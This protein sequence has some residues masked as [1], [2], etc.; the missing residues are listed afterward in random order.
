[1][2]PL[3]IQHSPDMPDGIAALRSA[4]NASENGSRHI[5]YDKVHHVLAEGNFVLCVCEGSRGGVHSSFYDLFRFYEG[6]IRGTL[7]YH[8]S[9]SAAR[10]VE[11]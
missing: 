3:Q 9:H 1:M 4:L 7:G 6:M 11:E 10:R 8:R 5:Q 2:G